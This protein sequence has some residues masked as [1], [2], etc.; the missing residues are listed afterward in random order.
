MLSGDYDIVVLD[1][2]NVT[3]WFGLLTVEEVMAL[4][5]ERPAH[6]ELILTGRRAPDELI[7]RADLVTEMREIKHYY[8]QGVVARKGIEK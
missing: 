1:E 2:I 6:V 3:V 8:Q 4:L 7:K 5:S